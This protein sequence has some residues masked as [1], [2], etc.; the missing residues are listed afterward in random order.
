MSSLWQTQYE[1]MTN[2]N[3][4]GCSLRQ[5]RFCTTIFVSVEFLMEKMQ[6]RTHHKIK[7]NLY[8]AVSHLSFYCFLFLFYL[9]LHM[10]SA[11]CFLLSLRPDM[12]ASV[13]HMRALSPRRLHRFSEDCWSSTAISFCTFAS[14][15]R[16][17]GDHDNRRRPL[18]SFGNVLW[19]GG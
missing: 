10:P 2:T 4:L 18:C 6:P 9:S 5:Y 7:Q 16:W 12:Q 3:S 8:S 19:F 1:A 15:R 11:S 13:C 17:C 14:N